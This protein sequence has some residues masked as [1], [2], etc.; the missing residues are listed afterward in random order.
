M[1][2]MNFLRS[3]RVQHPAIVVAIALATA[4]VCMKA[5]SGGGPTQTL[6]VTSRLVVL[7]VRVVDR[8][9]HFVPGLDRSQ[10]TVYEDREQQTIHDFE[11]PSSSSS[12]EHEVLGTAD[13][14]KSG[15]RSV[16]VLII[17]ELNIPHSEISRARSALTVYL[18]H[19]PS[20]LSVPTLFVASGASR[21][22]VLNDFT[23]SRDDLLAALKA[24]VSDVD[25]RALSNQL[26]GGTMGPAQ[27]FAKTLGALSQLASSLRGIRG[28]K[29]VIWVGSGFDK[30]FD[31]TSAGSNDSETIESAVRTVT[32]RMMDARMSLSTLDPAGM[33]AQD[34]Q[35]NIDAEATLGGGGNT[36]TNFTQGISFDELAQTT[37]GTVVHGRNDL[38]ALVKQTTSAAD[39]FYT[40]AYQPAALSSAPPDFTKIHVVMKDPSLTAVTRTGYFPTASNP[41]PT[42]SETAQ[43]TLQYRFDLLSAASS[44]LDYTGLQVSAQKNGNSGFLVQ[45]RANDLTWATVGPRLTADVAVLAVAFDSKDNIVAQRA[46]DFHEQ[47]KETDQIQGAHVT[48]AVPLNFP[49]ATQRV[50]FVVRDAGTGNV[51]S[52]EL[53]P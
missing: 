11:A 9:G 45:V 14:L 30:G 38:I 7:D 29:N 8:S 15:S 33:D 5:Q 43:Q 28:H 42:P 35:E 16:N 46:T 20:T 39:E 50:R 10:F 53:A 3:A 32:A 49:R 13:L 25:F 21:L 1:A 6:H 36:L 34:N 44:R 27:G 26:A 2:L 51:G 4:N 48:L 40:I 41:H 52:S 12:A 37:G 19:Q 22:A 31:L 18:E 23:Q 24:H 17:D 47:I